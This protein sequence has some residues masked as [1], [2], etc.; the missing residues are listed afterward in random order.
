MQAS[1]SNPH[2]CTSVILFFSRNFFNFKDL[3]MEYVFF[4]N[5]LFFVVNFI[6]CSDMS[7]SGE[8]EHSFQF[9]ILERLEP[10]SLINFVKTTKSKSLFSMNLEI[11]SG[12]FFVCLF[13]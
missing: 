2:R 4:S 13:M 10:S 1:V 8:D 7:V 11:F 9:S 12:R 3:N 6:S 5:T